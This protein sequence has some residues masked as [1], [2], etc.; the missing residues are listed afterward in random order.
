MGVFRERLSNYVPASFPFGFE[1]RV[2]VGW[3]VVC[4]RFNGPSRQ[5]FSLYRA[6]SQREEERGKKG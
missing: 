6:V 4:Y 5:Y 2:W 1:C 3:L